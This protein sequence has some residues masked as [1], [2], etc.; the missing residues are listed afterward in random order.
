MCVHRHGTPLPPWVFDMQLLLPVA[1]HS[2]I[3]V[4]MQGT[5]MITAK[6]AFSKVCTYSLIAGIGCPIPAI[7][8]LRVANCLIY[9]FT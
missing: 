9:R 6:P 2:Q 3:F 1:G 8:T 4:Y 7:F 5:R